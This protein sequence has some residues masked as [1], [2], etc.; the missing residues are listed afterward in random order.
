MKDNS[1]VNEIYD[2]IIDGKIDKERAINLLLSI[3]E[4]SVTPRIRIYVLKILELMSVRSI[5]IFKAMENLLISDEN[6]EV[7]KI[8]AKLIITHYFK[9][10]IESLKWVLTHE[11]SPL[12][13]KVLFDY[14]ELTLSNS[15]SS[16]SFQLSLK[17]WLTTFSHQLGIVPEESRFFLDIEALFSKDKKKSKISV[18][19][20]EFCKSLSDYLEGKPWLVINEGHVTQMVFNFANWK[21]LKE[22]EGD[23]KSLFNISYLDLFFSYI[24]KQKIFNTGTLKIP[25]T[26]GTLKFIKSLNLS[27]NNL[28]ELPRTLPNLQEL[29]ELNL[30]KNKFEKIPSEIFRLKK[31]EEIDLSQNKIHEIPE[32]ILSL[33][34]L[35]SLNLSYNEIKNFPKW[36]GKEIPFTL[37]LKNNPI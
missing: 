33:N 26:I 23:F 20:Y 32:S 24:N 10:G 14:S 4:E 36:L 8:A 28:R 29:K 16:K 1:T 25:E 22:L 11:T 13:I 2:G 30:S 17:E 9:E 6:P 21:Y 37:N 27:N 15:E 31:L 3:L 7:R 12:I 35:K 18:E 5:K 34:S 19:I